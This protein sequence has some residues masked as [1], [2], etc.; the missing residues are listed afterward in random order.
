MWLHYCYL[1]LLP[2]LAAVAAT[3]L[4]LGT[5]F[6]E[7]VVLCGMGP[8]L[9]YA[10]FL[11]TGYTLPNSLPIALV[12]TLAVPLQIA[13][14][15]F[16]FGRR[17]GW[18]FVAEDVTVEIGAF[19]IGIMFTALPN[20][21]RKYGW[22]HSVF[23]LVFAGAIFIGGTIPYFVMVIRGYGGLSLW[24]LLFATSFMTAFSHYAK[25]YGQ[26]IKANQKTGE[27][28]ELELRYDGGHVTR[29]LGLDSNVAVIAPLQ[30]RYKKGDVRGIPILLGFASFVA[31]FI[32]LAIM[33]IAEN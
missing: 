23:L 12:V 5:T 18:L 21:H 10:L 27:L 17:S 26:A 32:A 1:L 4:G 16:V 31:P 33:E 25:L 11:A 22:K 6:A 24:L 7:V 29:L 8:V 15:V 9:M 2:A 14:S 28:Q 30:S 13:L 20:V 19:V 3:R